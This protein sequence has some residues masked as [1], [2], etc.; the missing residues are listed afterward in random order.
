MAGLFEFFWFLRLK[1]GQ[2]I[3]ACDCYGVASAVASSTKK[4]TMCIT[5]LKRTN[6]T[7]MKT[8]M[9]PFF[10]CWHFAILL[11]SLLG[12]LLEF[13]FSQCGFCYAKNSGAAWL[14]SPPRP[15]RECWWRDST[16]TVH[17]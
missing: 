4:K 16:L 12:G 17:F 7:A 14:P 11:F 6:G 9:S 1:Y 2:P 8:I 3:G 5:I 13:G 15:Q 10:S